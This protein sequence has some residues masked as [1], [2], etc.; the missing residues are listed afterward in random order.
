VIGEHEEEYVKGPGMLLAGDPAEYLTIIRL[1]IEPTTGTIGP[2][3]RQSGR[4][5][6]SPVTPP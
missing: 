6:M 4:S 2:A 3:L 1:R 5:S